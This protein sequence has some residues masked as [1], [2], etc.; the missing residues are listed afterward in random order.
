MLQSL[1]YASMSGT[2]FFNSDLERAFECFLGLLE[3]IEIGVQSSKPCQNL[4]NIGV[5]GALFS[6]IYS[7]Q[8]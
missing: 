8:R 5:L 7:H 2:Q 1:T 3:P 6:E 4:S